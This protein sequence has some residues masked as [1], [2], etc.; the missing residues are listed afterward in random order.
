[1]TS[2]TEQGLVDFTCPEHG[3]LV[4]TTHNA[5]ITCGDCGWTSPRVK[6]P[7]RVVTPRQQAYDSD[8]FAYDFDA[9]LAA[10]EENE[11]AVGAKE[12]AAELNPAIRFPIFARSRTSYPNKPKQGE[13]KVVL[14]ED[15]PAPAPEELRRH[16]HRF[17][18]ECVQEV[19]DAYGVDLAAS[20]EARKRKR[21]TAT[22]SKRA[23]AR[24]RQVITEEAAL[25]QA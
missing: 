5:Q 3:F 17:G 20:T 11:R 13:G 2:L 6:R 9:A 24:A 7:G 4:A 22:R 18:S 23:T 14:V 25:G 21:L 12:K 15:L 16:A 10:S 19:A 1:M 8:P